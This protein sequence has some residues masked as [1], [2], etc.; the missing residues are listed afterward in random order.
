MPPPRPPGGVIFSQRLKNGWQLA[1]EK[2]I[3]LCNTFVHHSE[4][5]SRVACLF[6]LGAAL[7]P[8]PFLALPVS[9][10]HLSRLLLGW[11]GWEE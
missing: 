1:R 6:V 8:S 9:L 3:E 11:P 2:G 5:P 7:A 10:F 4:I